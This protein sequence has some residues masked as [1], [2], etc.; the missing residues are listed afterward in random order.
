VVLQLFDAAGPDYLSS[1]GCCSAWLQTAHDLAG[2]LFAFLFLAVRFI[3]FPYVSI[4]RVLPDIKNVASNGT[5]TN[6]LYGM[7][8]LN[9]L[10]TVL[11]LY[12]GSLV[13]REII[14]QAT[15]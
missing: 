14:K 4:T 1:S 15:L 10:F 11:Q 12:W 5:Y 3:Y 13:I 6:A 2:P 9:V 8:L 7:G